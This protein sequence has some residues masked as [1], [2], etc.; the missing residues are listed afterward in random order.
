MA[1]TIIG[2][3]IEHVL[4]KTNEVDTRYVR[5]TEKEADEFL[6]AMI[7]NDLFPE[8]GSWRKVEV[9]A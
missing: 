1:K 6:S 2:Y 7:E 8:I 4:N 5:E 9:Y 3:A